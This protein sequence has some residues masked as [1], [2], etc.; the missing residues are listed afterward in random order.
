MSKHRKSIAALLISMRERGLSL[1]S[2]LSDPIFQSASAEILGE[3]APEVVY[4][5]LR[6]FCQSMGQIDLSEWLADSQLELIEKGL[7][8]SVSSVELLMPPI[9][10]DAPSLRPTLKVGQG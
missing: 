8:K 4:N 6:M 5:N 7:L 10:A 3:I 9:P 2:V 1:A